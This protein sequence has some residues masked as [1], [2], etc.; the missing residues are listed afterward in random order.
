MKT[1]TTS[2][3]KD[4]DKNKNQLPIVID[5]INYDAP[6]HIVYLSNP[7]TG[8]ELCIYNA[9]GKIVYTCPTVDGQTEYI[10]PV[11]QLQKGTL[12]VIKY[13]TNDKIRRKEG[14]VK[15]IL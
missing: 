8:N 15:F 12:Y 5:T 7:K 6:T 14:W 10:I 1:A 3:D 9:Q 13:I 2:D 4:K 11:E